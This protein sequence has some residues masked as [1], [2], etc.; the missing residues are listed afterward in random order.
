MIYLLLTI[1]IPLSIISRYLSMLPMSAAGS[2]RVRS[3]LEHPDVVTFGALVLPEPAPDSAAS[4]C[5]TLVSS[6][7]GWHC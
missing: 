4:S 7:R 3:V 5:A 2:E 6:A 1:S